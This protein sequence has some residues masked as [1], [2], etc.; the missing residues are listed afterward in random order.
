MLNSKNFLR[1]EEYRSPRGCRI[2]LNNIVLRYPVG[3]LLKG[4]IKSAFFTL[5]G[6]KP[7]DNIQREYVTALDGFSLTINRG[8]RL[9]IIGRN[10][11]GKSTLLQTIAGVYP[12][13]SGAISVEGKIQGLFN[14]GLGFEQDSTGRENIF[15]RGL[16]MGCGP[17]EIKE[18]MHDI[19][20]FADIGEF[21]DLPVR[22]Y[23]S[24]MYVRL[25][26]AIST[27]L[28]GD[29]LLIDEVFGAGDAQF[30]KKASARI[31]D[32]VNAAGIVVM[33]GHDMHT[34]QTVCSRVLWIERGK[35]RADGPKDEVIKAYLAAC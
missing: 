26:F 25:A 13:S 23:S 6:H 18:R 16:A 33:V 28:Q 4:S 15:Y 31:L 34:L 3:P 35:L 8:E 14:I 22:T 32:L 29:I 5:L 17:D 27:Y 19:I 11:A 20:E 24:G 1:A 2:Q 30:Q 21:I 10:G 7:L 12:I 9:G